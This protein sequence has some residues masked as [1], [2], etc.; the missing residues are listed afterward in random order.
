MTKKV[1]N[2]VIIMIILCMS[3][4]MCSYEV[5]AALPSERG[6]DSQSKESTLEINPET[7]NP[8]SSDNASG[9]TRIKDMGNIIIGSI[10]IIASILSV[11]LLMVMGIKYMVGSVEEKA[12]Y[13]K[14]M[15][16]YV[17]GIIMVFSITTILGIIANL[18]KNL[19]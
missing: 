1:I 4:N 10:Q 11:I 3:I 7:Y 9:A 2:L 8:G 13:K 6:T 17:I 12:E 19:L 16:P 14:T 5:C 18:S 15:L